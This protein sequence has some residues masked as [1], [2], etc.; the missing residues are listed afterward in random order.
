M[1]GF[2]PAGYSQKLQSIQPDTVQWRPLTYANLQN[3][4]VS[5]AAYGDLWA[6]EIRQNNQAYIDR[7][8]TGF[9]GR[10]ALAIEA[11]LVVRSPDPKY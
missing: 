11:H 10:N 2:V 6:N 1:L 4:T 8:E 7:G 5:A 3:T 9:L